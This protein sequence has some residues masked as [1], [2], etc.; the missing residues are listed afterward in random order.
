MFKSNIQS[1]DYFLMYQFAIDGYRDLNMYHFGSQGVNYSKSTVSDVKTINLPDD[2]IGFIRLYLPYNGQEWALTEN[3]D[4]I[5]TLTLDG[6]D[7]TLDSD[8]GEGVDINDGSTGLYGSVGGKNSNYYAIDEA[9][10]RIHVNLDVN[11]ELVL[12]YK[13]SGIS[14][15]DTSY[16]PIQAEPVIEMYM[17][18]QLALHRGT[19]AD[20]EYFKNEYNEQVTKLRN[21]VRCRYK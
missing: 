10:R 6:G 8:Y 21:F 16:I 14:L 18:W 1:S 17:K 12:V 4:I 13:S 9:N 3:T 15:D 5:K 2:Y 11:S 19:K 20:A 7:Y